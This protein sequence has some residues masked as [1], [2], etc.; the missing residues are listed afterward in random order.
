MWLPS[1]SLT[2]PYATE[3]LV[4]GQS[5]GPKMEG[6]TE[7]SLQ[8][9]L[10]NQGLQAT[11]RLVPV[12]PESELPFALETYAKHRVPSCREGLNRGQQHRKGW[13]EPCHQCALTPRSRL[14]NTPLPRVTLAIQRVA[15]VWLPCGS[16]P[17]R[18]ELGPQEGARVG[19]SALTALSFS[20]AAMSG[21]VVPPM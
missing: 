8:F 10:G 14:P 6:E 21:L 7:A 2:H 9:H 13:Q 11:A 5:L 4:R 17:R 20:F 1:E 15:R 18:S 12:F 3:L 19:W 16:W